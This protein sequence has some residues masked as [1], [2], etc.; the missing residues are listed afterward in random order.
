MASALTGGLF[1]A[2]QA[3][4]QRIGDEINEFKQEAAHTEVWKQEAAQTEERRKSVQVDLASPPPQKQPADGYVA[5]TY[6]FVAVTPSPSASKFS[7]D[8]GPTERAA[9]EPTPAT[10]VAGQGAQGAAALARRVKELEESLR[11]QKGRAVRDG[12]AQGKQHSKQL[13]EMRAQFKRELEAA[14]AAAVEG[15]RGEA[16]PHDNG[17]SS[18]GGTSS[19]VSTEVG[20]AGGSVDRWLQRLD[21]MAAVAEAEAE[22][23]TAAETAAAAAETAASEAAAAGETVPPPLPPPRPTMCGKALLVQL[24]RLRKDVSGALAVARAEGGGGGGGGGGGEG[25]ASSGAAVAVVAVEAVAAAPPAAAAPAAGSAALSSAAAAQRQQQQQQ[26]EQHQ[27]EQQ[28]RQISALE[29]QVESLATALA[30]EELNSRQKAEAARRHA[31]GLEERAEHAEAEVLDRMTLVADAM[32]A[33]EVA[34]SGA[35]SLEEELRE[36]RSKAGS[37][38]KQLCAKDKKLEEEVAALRKE[39]NESNLLAEMNASKES[40]LQTALGLMRDETE[41]AG[42]TVK[43]LEARHAQ[44]RAY[45]RALILR[46]LE[47]ESQHEACPHRPP[48]TTAPLAPRARAATAPRAGALSRHRHLLQVHRGGGGPPCT[49]AGGARLRDFSARPHAQRWLSPV[50]RRAR[51]FAGEVTGV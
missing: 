31:E 5:S 42:K 49:Q 1:G 3:A 10:S 15:G 24:R 21:S 9:L 45:L 34:K 4:Q 27:L 18:S 11:E 41:G 16:A 20:G 30:K 47:M 37:R 12:L 28:Q 35:A 8:A 32:G 38:I 17:V 40:S 23:E 2:L 44:E 50:W 48:P 26:L 43:E 6:G 25:A 22:A 13:G 19:A 51:P 39:V 46:Y 14:A 36:V 7:I 33:E 29:E